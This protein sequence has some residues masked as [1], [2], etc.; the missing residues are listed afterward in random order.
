MSI[1][2]VGQTLNLDSDNQTVGISLTQLMTRRFLRNRLAIAGLVVLC[3]IYLSA[4]FA[5]FLSPTKFDAVDEDFIFVAPQIPRFFDQEGNFHPRPFVYG[6]ETELDPE[7]FR[8]VHEPNPEIIYPIHF[9]VKGYEYNLLW[10][11]PMNLHLFGVEEPGVIYLF[12]SDS[13]GRDMLSRILAG[14]RISLTIGLVGVSL[15]VLFGSTLGTISGYYGGLVD[16]LVQR[17]TEFLMSFPAIP[18][19]AAFAA[20]MP[21]NWSSIQRFFAI[22]VI[23]SLIQ[24]TGLARQVRAKVLSFREMDYTTAAISAGAKDRRIIFRHLL[25]N[26]FSH[27]IVVATLAIPGMILAESALSFLGLGIQPPMTSWGVLLQEAQFVSVLLQQPWLL[28]P[29][30]FIILAVLSFNFVGD[31]LRDA[32]DPFSL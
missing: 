27:I 6:L 30:F 16:M 20:A 19:W 29:A 10:L 32:A 5:D 1:Q 24:W 17:V 9:L 14:A 2:R 3:A 7:T 12:G 26:A 28:I 18:L 23:L 25:P 8:W 15:T 21:A 11:F 22:S 4:I 13:L 31:G